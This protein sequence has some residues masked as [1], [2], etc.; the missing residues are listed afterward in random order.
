[1]FIPTI[2][3]VIISIILLI[4]I[5]VSITLYRKNSILI[6]T[7]EKSLAA[8]DSYLQFF[9]NLLETYIGVYSKLKRVDRKG[10]FES[11]DEIGFVFKSIKTTI[12]DLHNQ[13]QNIQEVLNGSYETEEKKKE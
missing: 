1:M 12:G 7:I 8:E 11:D 10:S 9:K 4:L 13:L 2:A 3:I 5:Y 6:D